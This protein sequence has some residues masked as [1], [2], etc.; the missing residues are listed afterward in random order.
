MSTGLPGL[1]QGVARN[2]VVARSLL[3]I[4]ELQLLLLAVAALALAASLLASQR[5]GETALLSARGGARWQL[6]RLGGAESAL[7][8]VVTVVVGGLAGGWLAARLARSGPLRAAGLHLAGVAG[9]VWWAA[10]W[11]A[12]SAPCCCSGRP[13]ARPRRAPR[14]PGWAGPAGP[15]ASPGPALTSRWW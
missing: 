13:S 8:G 4:G 5:E 15:R 11:S 10:A 9:V 1:L 6:A 2:D 12:C 14:E 3:V 7:L